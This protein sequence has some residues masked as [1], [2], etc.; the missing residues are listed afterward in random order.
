MRAIS[1][2]IVVWNSHDAISLRPRPIP[3]DT[4][5]RID[6]RQIVNAAI[7]FDQQTFA[8]IAEIENVWT[9]RDLA[10]KV[11]AFEHFQ[12]LP[13]PRFRRSRRSAEATGACVGGRE[14]FLAI[15][16]L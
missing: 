2:R 9:E 11:E 5:T 16:V 6:F 3:L 10:T 12:T 1:R 4:V 15:H 8:V 7:Q 13:E 14:I